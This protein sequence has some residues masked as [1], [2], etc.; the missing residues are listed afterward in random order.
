MPEIA[1]AQA[2]LAALAETDEV[3]AEAARPSPAETFL[4]ASQSAR[5]ARPEPRAIARRARDSA[6]GSTTAE[7][8]RA[9]RRPVER[10]A[11]P[12]S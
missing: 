6:R 9:W 5:Q 2:L 3:K 8:R 7:E 11:T 10:A 12:G 1:A 4:D